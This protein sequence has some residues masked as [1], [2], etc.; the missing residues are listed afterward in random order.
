MDITQ[1]WDRSIADP[2][3]SDYYPRPWLLTCCTRCQ[4]CH[5]WARPSYL[6]VTFA[7]L[8]CIFREVGATGRVK[9]GGGWG[10]GA[11][12]P[13]LG[14]IS[15]HSPTLASLYINFEAIRFYKILE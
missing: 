4:P 12:A 15:W 11:I 9:R 10:R 7:Q 2:H 8:D 13:L 14:I 1:L 3:R 6:Q 5:G